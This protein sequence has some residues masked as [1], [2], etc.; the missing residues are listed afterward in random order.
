MIHSSDV[1][2]VSE[3]FLLVKI[4]DGTK[5]P[6]AV[7]TALI[8]FYFFLSFVPIEPNAYYFSLLFTAHLELYRKHNTFL[9]KPIKSADNTFFYEKY[10]F[11]KPE[12]AKNIIQNPTKIN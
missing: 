3:I 10:Y 11:L 12:Q 7:I 8:V 6:I 9:K 5:P 2:T 1:S 4:D